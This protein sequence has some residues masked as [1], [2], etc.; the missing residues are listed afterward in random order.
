M[1]TEKEKAE[2]TIK[3]MQ[4][5]EAML[6]QADLCSLSQKGLRRHLKTQINSIKRDC[7]NIIERN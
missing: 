2:E 4:F 5:F 1:E 6:S 3:W 7:K